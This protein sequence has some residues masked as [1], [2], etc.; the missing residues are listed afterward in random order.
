[1]SS[2]VLIDIVTWNAVRASRSFMNVFS[3]YLKLL[4]FKQFRSVQSNLKQQVPFF[5]RKS[6]S[7]QDGIHT[8]DVTEVK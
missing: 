4:L 7:E 5:R 6:N 1:M 2:P 8:R 3:A